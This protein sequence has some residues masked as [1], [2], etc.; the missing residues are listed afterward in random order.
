MTLD[1]KL[2]LFMYAYKI[3]IREAFFI[4]VYVCNYISWCWVWI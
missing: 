2:Q 1:N 4:L 3:L